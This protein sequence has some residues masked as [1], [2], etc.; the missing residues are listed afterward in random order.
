M[1]ARRPKP[2]A[3]NRRRF[4]HVVAASVAAILA[5]GV[6]RARAAAAK[7]IAPRPAKPLPAPMERELRNQEKG[8]A[9]TLKV[10]RAYE[11]PPGREPA[12]VFRA[13]RARRGG[14]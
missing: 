4:V 2:A 10:I 5:G 13:M 12:T 1:N 9:D 11:L 7:A 6:P 14:R 3:M 8:I